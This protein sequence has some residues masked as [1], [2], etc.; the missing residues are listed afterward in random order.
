[1]KNLSV[2]SK[3]KNGL[4]VSCQALEGEPL[5]MPGFMARMA[6][7]AEMAGAAGIRSNGANDIMEIRREVSLPLIGLVKRQYEDSTVYITPT[8]A[9]IQE[10][11]QAGA[12][13]IAL[14]ATDRTRPGGNT[15]DSFYAQVRAQYP[16]LLLMADC[17]TYEEGVHAAELGFDLLGTTLN[18]YTENTRGARLPD[19][20]LIE[21]LAA[22]CR[23]PLIAE[24]GIWSPEDMVRAFECGAYA[25]V[26]G[27]AITRPYEITKRFVSKLNTIT[28]KNE[29]E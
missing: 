5:H 17:A 3:M 28:F 10:L 12:N 9:E 15:L 29:L 6:K 24:G 27:S 2:I 13:I 11:A 25:V 4:V 16:E 8:L 14:D 1:M 18:G 21:R 7:A 22:S 20:A 23:V 26:V 19:F